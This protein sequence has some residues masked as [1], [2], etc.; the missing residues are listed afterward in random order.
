MPNIS[1]LKD[2]IPC[3]DEDANPYSDVAIFNDGLKW[4]Y[5]A[6]EWQLVK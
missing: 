6:N 3:L 4:A 5:S 1:T 2:I